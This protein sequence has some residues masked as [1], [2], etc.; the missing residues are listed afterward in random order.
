M[1][2]PP[3]KRYHVRA[4]PLPL[5]GTPSDVRTSAPVKRLLF[6]AYE[7][8]P[9]GGTQAQHAAKLAI[10]LAEQGWDITAIAVADPPT[11]LLDPGLE[12][13]TAEKVRIE[14][15]WSL[16][17]TRLV[18]AL[19]RRRGAS[20]ESTQASAPPV[21]PPGSS[22][23]SE[24]GFSGMPRWAIRGVQALF[25]PDEKV[26]WTPYVIRLGER[27]HREAPFDAIFATGP[28]FS[29]YRAARVLSKHLGIPYVADLRDPIVEGY[30]FKPLTA[31]ND[32]AI[33]RFEKRTVDSA[34]LVVVLIPQ[35]RDAIL[36]RVAAAPEKFFVYPN[37]FDPADFASPPPAAAEGFTVSYGGAFQATI[38]P[39]TFLAAV[40]QLRDS[41]PQF[42]RDIR[43][44]F[45]G[46]LDTETAE[47]IERTGTVDVVERTG[48]VTHA[49]AV[50]AMRSSAVNLL[51][52]GPEE[53]SKGIVTS[54]L[55]EYLAAERPI[56]ALVPS[57]GV[58]ADMI[59]AASAGEIVQPLD[60][61][62]A[63][64]ALQRLHGAWTRGEM[65]TP[66]PTAVAAYDRDRATERLSIAIEGVVERRGRI[67]RASERPRVLLLAA[68]NS[69]SG[70]GERHV[71]DL[72]ERLPAA[73][74]DVSLACPPGGDLT[75][76]A[77][78]LGI[79]VTPVDIASGMSSAKL[80]SVRDAIAAADPDVVHAHGSRAALFARL[81]DS[82][83]KTRCVY[84]VH[85]IHVDKAGSA[86]RRTVFLGLERSLR[87]RTAHFVTVCESDVE[88]GARLGVLDPAKATVVYNGIA[89]PAESPARGAFRAE[90]GLAADAP[91]VLSVGRFH[92]QKDQATLLRGWSAVLADHPD[93]VLALV[94]SGELESRLREV[95]RAQRLGDS[96]R[97]VAPRGGLTDAYA[98][99]DILA[100]SSLW[101]GLPYVVL[102]AMSFGVPVVATAV[103]GVPEAVVDGV[104]GLLVPPA[105]PS[106]LGSA[107]AGLLGHPERRRAMGEA[108]RV[109]VA[110]RFSLEGMID[111]LLGVYANVTAGSPSSDAR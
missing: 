53:A 57:D 22:G 76:L 27:L 52:L 88:K 5:L 25:V 103:D 19:R 55:P 89:L 99:A 68:A 82:H 44:R 32:A 102:E 33:R 10:A 90:L 73:G 65:T 104:T 62:G 26:G 6:I 42:A 106:A 97:F 18:Q 24:R 86:A 12:Q 107:L 59:R 16:E 39:D 20:S 95:A 15:A 63:A 87:S 71:A 30:F 64:G 35:L 108:G 4:P 58:A 110:E 37:C 31:A 83:A 75:A 46:P 34:A 49:E 40:A 36:S 74:V 61:D 3:R 11:A 70:G 72:L 8:P 7:F 43:V 48:F 85:G 109:L 41:D 28:P 2:V 9:K 23:G 60:V 77:Q 21:A 13:E 14:R 111:G 91:L 92:E 17:P 66:D 51:V 101:E 80:R 69:T 100:L 50:A 1:V 67:A 93:A 81:A 54:K 45:V 38:R 96:V 105:D 79:P 56:L 94:G 78:R 84:T 98:D 47:A 29:A